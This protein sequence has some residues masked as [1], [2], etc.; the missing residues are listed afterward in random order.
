MTRKK[1][2]VV[3]TSGGLEPMDDGRGDHSPFAA[4]LFRTLRTNL[5]IRDG[6]RLFDSIRSPVMTA[7]DQIPEY[8][9]VRKAAHDG[10]DFIFV[11]RN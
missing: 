5:G 7:A 8:S 1:A 11:K 4:A 10:G 6:T 9:D 3:I 2:R